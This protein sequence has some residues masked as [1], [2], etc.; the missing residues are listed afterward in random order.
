M[1]GTT[2]RT[3]EIYTFPAGGRSRRPAGTQSPPLVV[4]QDGSN[5]GLPTLSATAC[6]AT[7]W[8]HDEEVREALG[9]RSLVPPRKR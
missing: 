4:S 8:Y 9:K 1:N 3:A 6:S 5:K 2:L 7:A